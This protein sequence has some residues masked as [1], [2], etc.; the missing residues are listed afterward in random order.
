M[1]KILV[2]EKLHKSGIELL[3]QRKDFSFEVIENVEKNFLKNKLKNCDGITLR[4]IEFGKELIESGKNL[5]IISRHGV[6]YDNLD[7]KAMKKNNVILSVTD[8]ANAVSVSEHIFFMM[9]NISRGFDK[10]D[11]FIRKEDFSKR[12]ELKLTT[13]IW[14]KKILIIGFGRIGKNLIKRC[15][16]FEMDIF[17]YD[18]Y[19]SESVINKFGGKKVDNYKESIK[20]MDYIS[21]N[22]PLTHETK[23]MI[24]LEILKKMKKNSIIIN[25]ARGGIIN[26]LDLNEA[27]NQKLIFGAGLDLFE[28]EPPS[29]E[30]PLLKNKKVFLTPH[31]ATFT[32]ECTKRMGQQTVQNLIDFFDGKLEKRSIIEL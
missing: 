19:V 15:Q 9:L 27:L 12:T 18:P 30:N 23:N 31:A 32:E 1:K 21:I 13:E 5:K 3:K 17:V 7:L 29:S 11:K 10:Y 28:N 4:N 20:T 24:N 16:G 25:T 2:I 8:T 14:N 6:G 26:E 22:T